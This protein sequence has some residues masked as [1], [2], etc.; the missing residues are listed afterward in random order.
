MTGGVRILGAEGRSKSVNITH[1]ASECLNIELTRDSQESGSTKEVFLVV[2]LSIRDRNH[3]LDW[4]RGFNFFLFRG[5]LVLLSLLV[6]LLLLG[7]LI[8][9]LF[10]VLLA[11]V[12]KHG[13]L[14]DRLVS[15]GHSCR[16]LEHFTSTFTIR[17]CNNRSVDVLETALLEEAM[18]RV[19][20]IVANAHHG[21]DGLRAA[22]HVC[23]VTQVLVR[24]L[25]L[26]EVIRFTRAL[27][28]NFD[29]V[30]LGAANLQFYEL[31]LGGRADQLT[32][33][34]ETS[35]SSLL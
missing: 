17:S 33:S 22:T 24:V 32:N 20:E 13:H 14:A 1:A 16:N 8:D 9:L 23:D 35:A 11:N 15:V 29:L 26:S 12:L 34:F 27:T 19:G 7:R 21:G 28:D 31:T 18:C 30:V 25:L 4:L 2:D 5:I 3:F 6:L 10:F